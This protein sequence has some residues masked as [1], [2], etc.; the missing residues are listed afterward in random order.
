MSVLLAPKTICV[1][2]ATKVYG[3][4]KLELHQRFVPFVKFWTDV[5]LRERHVVRPTAT[6]TSERRG[7]WCTTSSSKLQTTLLTCNL[8]CGCGRY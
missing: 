2:L 1:E 5:R 3:T 6:A 7:L 4:L 8:P